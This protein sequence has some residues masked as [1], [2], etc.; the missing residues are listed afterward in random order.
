MGGTN[1]FVRTLEAEPKEFQTRKPDFLV[2]IN[3]LCAMLCMLYKI[4]YWGY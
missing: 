2:T 1:Q 3:L 4:E